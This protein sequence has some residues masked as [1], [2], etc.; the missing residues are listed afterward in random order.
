MYYIRTNVLTQYIYFLQASL[1]SINRTH[2]NCISHAQHFTGSRDQHRHTIRLQLLT[3]HYSIY[4][5][6][7]ASHIL[8]LFLFCPH[9][10]PR[11]CL[12]VPCVPKNVATTGKAAAA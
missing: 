7:R 4:A 10:A 2:M 12:A 8:F 11:G 3:A 1:P 5:E 6:R 9:S